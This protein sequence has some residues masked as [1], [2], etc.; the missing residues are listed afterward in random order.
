MKLVFEKKIN[1]QVKP[2]VTIGICV[3]NCEVFIKEAIESVANQDFP[4]ELMEIIVVDDGSEDKTLSIVLN[5]VSKVDIHVKVFH[6]RWIGLGPARNIVVENARRPFEGDAQNFPSKIEK[7]A[8]W[9][10]GSFG[11]GFG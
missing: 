2:K 11:F 6:D 4:H 9:K 10:T 8:Y 3:R 7:N 5:L 1:S